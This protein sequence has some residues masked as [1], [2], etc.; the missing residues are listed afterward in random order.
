MHRRKVNF[1]VCCWIALST[2]LS[3]TYPAKAQRSSLKTH[4]Q[5]AFVNRSPFKVMEFWVTD[6]KKDGYDV[7]FLAAVDVEPGNYS[8]QDIMIPVA[9]PCFLKVEVGYWD[10]QKGKKQYAK[11]YN[12]NICVGQRFALEYRRSDENIFLTIE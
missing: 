9:Q 2:V 12:Q 4:H 8:T 1:H 7:D 5:F 6:G 3:A 11:F 10:P